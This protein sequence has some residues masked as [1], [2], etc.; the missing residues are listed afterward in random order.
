MADERSNEPII[1]MYHHIAAGVN[2]KDSKWVTD[3]N[4]SDTWD[5]MAGE[6]AAMR[7]KGIGFET[8]HDIA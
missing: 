7:N 4:S 2:K 6:M 8:V 1:G 3:K 5:K